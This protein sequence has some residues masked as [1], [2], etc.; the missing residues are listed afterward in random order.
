MRITLSRDLSPRSKTIAFRGTLNFS[1]KNLSKAVFAFPSTA[2][3]RSLI[4]QP[5]G[6]SRNRRRNGRSFS[7]LA[8]NRICL[9]LARSI[10]AYLTLVGVDP[11]SI[12]R[13]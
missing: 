10:Q 12:G 1:A 13:V 8:C 7:R 2:G 11:E 4:V 9:A 5:G 3:A 6:A